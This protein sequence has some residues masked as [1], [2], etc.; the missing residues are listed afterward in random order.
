MYNSFSDVISLVG[1]VTS[2][3]FVSFQTYFSVISCRAFF[4]LILNYSEVQRLKKKINM[5][6]R[7]LSSTRIERLAGQALRNNSTFITLNKRDLKELGRYH[8]SPALSDVLETITQWCSKPPKGFEKFSKKSHVQGLN[9]LNIQTVAYTGG[10]A[11]G[12]LLGVNLPP[13]P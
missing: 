13:P 4:R 2:L 1:P 6:W 9:P 7:F 3:Q 10:G 12:L 8:R 5:Y 11:A